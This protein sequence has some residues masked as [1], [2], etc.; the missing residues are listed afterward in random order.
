MEENKIIRKVTVVGVA[1]N[2][3]LVVFKLY[4]GI[5]G[6]S[7]AM[8]SDAVHSLSD[9][10]ATFV[11]FIGV[12]ISKKAPDKEHPYGHDR[13]E[14]LASF[15]LGCILLAT[16]IGIGVAGVKTIIAGDFDSLQVPSLIALIAAIV[17]IVT[18]EIMFWYTRHCAKKINSSA[19]MADAWHH[20]SDALSSV[21]SLAGIIFARMGF[22]I[23]DPIACVII[24]IFILKVAF[25]IL[26]DSISNMLDTSCG[27]EWNS[28]MAAFICEQVGVDKVDLIQSRKFG[29]KIYLDVEIAVDGN[30]SLNEAHDIA[31][32][33]HD[34]VEKKYP[35][36][37]HI[38]IHENPTEK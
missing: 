26:K 24:C 5:V 8:V 21:G 22:P 36:I 31:E 34:E 16:G 30:M 17:S 25:D 4:A 20:R 28:G 9:V 19:F 10:F 29:N 27:D 6:K 15:L 18:K 2:I 37:K 11:A 35:E 7:G 12:R 23:M 13:F 14:T 33:V 1:G 3:A 32:R 38:M